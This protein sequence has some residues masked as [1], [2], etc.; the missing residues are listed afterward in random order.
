MK[1]ESLQFA[2]SKQRKKK[3]MNKKNKLKNAE[4]LLA[5]S[6]PFQLL[7]KYFIKPSRLT[8]GEVAEKLK[9][10]PQDI[11]EMR[12][13]TPEIA[14]RFERCFGWP[15]QVLLTWQDL[16]DIEERLWGVE[17]FATELADYV[18]GQKVSLAQLKSRDKMLQKERPFVKIERVSGVKHLKQLLAKL[19]REGT[20][21][22][23]W[24][25]NHSKKLSIF[26]K[27]RRRT[28]ARRIEEKKTFNKERD[29][30]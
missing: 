10:S 26:G 18:Q 7:L 19:E 4:W 8:L 22:I 30:D 21:E 13:I 27:I 15:A 23:F 25:H 3:Q 16:Y 2:R 28:P 29:E 9:M 17:T 11:I 12:K 6:R 14:E 20:L 1:S 24:V 5:R